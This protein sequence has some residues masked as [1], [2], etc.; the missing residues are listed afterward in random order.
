MSKSHRHEIG[1][2]LIVLTAAALTGWMA[3]KVGSFGMGGHVPYYRRLQRRR[4]RPEE[5]R[6]REHC[7]GERR[8]VDTLEIEQGQARLTLL[9]DPD[10]ALHQ[11]ARALIRARS[12]LGEKYIAIEPAAP[13]P[14]HWTETTFE[15]RLVK[16]RSTN[17]SPRL[18]PFS[19]R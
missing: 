16:S 19:T 3:M 15:S 17:S 5:Q 1:V 2:G 10:I 8:K 9:I 14:A 13:S 18:A 12:V 4:S 11:D 7:R 6:Q